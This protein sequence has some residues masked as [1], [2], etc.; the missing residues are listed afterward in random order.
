MFG[1]PPAEI[2]VLR[3]AVILMDAVSVSDWHGSSIFIRSMG[4]DP[5]TSIEELVLA[6]DH[7]GA[8]RPRSVTY[9]SPT[10][11]CTIMRRCTLS[12]KKIGRGFDP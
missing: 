7:P 3:R 1:A 10:G 11:R 4:L 12:D 9:A 2:I 8:P 5:V 6:L